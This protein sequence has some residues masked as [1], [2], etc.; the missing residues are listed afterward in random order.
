L[1]QL[2]QQLKRASFLQFL[3]ESFRWDRKTNESRTTW[4]APIAFASST[5][6]S[7]GCKL[8]LTSISKLTC[9]KNKI[10]STQIIRGIHQ[11][12]GVIKHWNIMSIYVPT[13]FSSLKQMGPYISAR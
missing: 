4:Y 9:H 8:P 3:K 5:T 13:V 1:A 11:I 10:K 7:L 12:H 6:V 2:K